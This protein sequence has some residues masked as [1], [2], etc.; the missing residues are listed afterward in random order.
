[1]DKKLNYYVSIYKMQLQNGD[2]QIAYEQLVKYVMTLK[3]HCEKV[4]S[5]KYS[6]GNVSP[7]YM[8]FTYFPFFDEFLRSEKLRFGIVLNH[9]KIRFELWLM[10]QNAQVQ[11]EYWEL[12]KSSVWNKNQPV[13]PKYSILEA[14]LVE[15]PDF[16]NLHE[17][18]VELAK[19]AEFLS[20]EIVDYIKDVGK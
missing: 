14:I 20:E 16:N 18:T 10:G 11:K 1:M 9:E 13:M 2:I 12:L 8:D 15:A 4:F 3:A 6:C 17:L 19:K 7:G 5:N